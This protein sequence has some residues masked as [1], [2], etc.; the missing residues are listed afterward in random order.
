VRNTAFSYCR[1]VE[2]STQTADLVWIEPIGFGVI[3]PEADREGLEAIEDLLPADRFNSIESSCKG[4][5]ASFPEHD[6]RVFSA[7]HILI[8]G[9]AQS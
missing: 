6:T 1:L 4:P 8:A 7:R 3:D 5:G 2:K 9:P